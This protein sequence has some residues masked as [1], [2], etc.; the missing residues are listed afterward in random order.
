[1]TAVCVIAT[2]ACTAVGLTA[3]AAAAAVRSAISGF[4]EYP[5]AMDLT[6]KPAIVAVPP[7]MADITDPAAAMAE[8]AIAALSQFTAGAALPVILTLP[9]ARPGLAPDF[10]AR[11]AA[12]VE[13]QL[14]GCRVTASSAGGHAGVGVALHQT[15]SFLDRN[16]DSI[17]A[18]VGVDSYLSPDTIGWLDSHRQLHA[19]YNAWGFIPGAAAGAC[20]LCHPKLAQTRPM[21]PRAIIEALSLDREEVPIKTDGVCLGRAMS[22]IVA[23]LVE[24]TPDG[25]VFDA[26]YCDQNGEAYR[27]DELGFMLA[28]SATRFRDPSNFVAP[29]DCWGDVGAASL[30]LFIALAVEAADRNYA[31]GP[32]SLLLAGS[33]SGLRAGLRL[34]TPM[35]GV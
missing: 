29:A 30:P 23:A 2:A 1:M 26:F 34:R 28:R 14:A 24:D 17:V 32:V 8:M 31:K 35:R 5:D 20:L 22:R 15:Q 7:G 27:A 4:E 21:P 11:V 19:T 10:A 16:P 12:L 18:L 3:P 13:N 25:A 33:E 6:H 9:E